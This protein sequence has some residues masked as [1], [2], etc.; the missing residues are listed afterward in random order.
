[1]AAEAR[2]DWLP[3]TFYD[4]GT[5][6]IR[7]DAL[8]KSYSE[9]HTKV[10]QRTEAIRAEVKAEMERAAREGVPSGPEGYTVEVPKDTLPAWFEALTPPESD[11]LLQAFRGI[12]HEAGLKPAQFKRLTDAV[13][14]YQAGMMV[15]VEAEMAKIGEGAAARANAVR[16]FLK[17]NLSEV[18]ARGVEAMTFTA[19][20]VTGLEKLIRM[21]EGQ[22]GRPMSTPG[23]GSGGGGGGPLTPEEARAAIRNPVHAQDGPEGDALRAKVE[24]FFAA[25][26]KIPRG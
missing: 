1:L 23:T 12:A 11:P 16:A 5:K 20:G 18:E 8:G 2:P 10:G 19:E 3:E 22:G 15:D 6:A 13:Y 17:Q 21:A 14:A 26:G 9:L 7:V 4:P 24:A 25:G